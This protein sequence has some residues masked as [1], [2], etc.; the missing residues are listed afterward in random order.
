M[1]IQYAYSIYLFKAYLNIFIQAIKYIY[2]SLKFYG[3][4]K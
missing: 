4:F 3:H 1:H 2:S